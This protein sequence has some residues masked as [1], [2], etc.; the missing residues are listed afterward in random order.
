MNAVSDNPSR[1]DS[2]CARRCRS[3]ARAT[4]ASAKSDA[5]FE[6]MVRHNA[7]LES[8]TAGQVPVGAP[9]GGGRATPFP[10]A[11]CTFPLCDCGGQK[12]YR[13]AKEIAAR[14]WGDAELHRRV[15]STKGLCVFRIGSTLHMLECSYIRFV[16]EMERKSQGK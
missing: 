2:R 6:A 15:Y 4:Q 12:L 9:A 16:R 1:C 14:I 8:E 3:P 5:C 11:P 7:R 13:G 10:V